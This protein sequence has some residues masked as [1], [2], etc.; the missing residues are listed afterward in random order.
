MLKRNLLR[1]QYFLEIYVEIY[2]I[3]VARTSEICLLK[4]E[5]EKRKMKQK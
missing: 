3:Q 2:V 5:E 4:K 1:N